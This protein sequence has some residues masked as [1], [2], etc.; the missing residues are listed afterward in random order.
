MGSVASGSWKMY[1]VVGEN[2]RVGSLS[3]NKF[4]ISE[5]VL[6]AE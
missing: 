1:H 4:K 5:G 2:I 3:F 6:S